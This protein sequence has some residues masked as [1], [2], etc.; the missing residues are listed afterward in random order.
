MQLPSVSPPSLDLVCAGAAATLLLLWFRPLRQRRW[1]LTVLAGAAILGACRASLFTSRTLPHMS[2]EASL[3]QSLPLDRD[4]DYVTSNRCQS[5]HPGEYASWHDTY[6]RTMTQPAN[7]DTVVGDFSGQTID[8]DG[9]SY[10][11]FMRGEEYWARLPDPEEMMEIVMGNKPKDMTKVPL[12]ERQVV[13]TTGSHHYQTYWVTGDE[14]YGRLLQTLPLVYLIGD[15]R[16]IPR[17]QAFMNAP[18][19]PRMITQWNHHCIKCHSTGGNPG[20]DDDV[21]HGRFDTQVA[22][23]G[24]SCEACHG[25]GE[26]HIAANRDPRRRYQQHRA[27]SDD[28]TIV[29]P[30]NL[31]HDRASQICGQCHG[32][33]IH[34]GEA[35]WR[36]AQEGLLYRP[37]DDLHAQRLYIEHPLNAPTKSNWANYRKNREYFRGR[38]WD[39]GTML[40][41][42]REYTAMRA[43]ACF[44][45]GHMSCLSC[46]S[47]HNSHPNDQL[48]A[49][50]NGN[51][52]CVQCHASPEYTVDV[53]AH[54]HHA[55]SSTGSECLNCHMPHIS[56][57]L[58]SAIRS[59]QVQAPNIDSS[60]K[61]GVPNACNLCHL[62]RT[63]EW[64]AEH[65]SNWYGQE[66][67]TPLTQEQTETS[68]ALL[69][70]LKGNAVQR[71]VTAWHVGWEPAREASGAAWLAPHQAQLL[72]DP[73][74]VVRYVAHAALRTLPGMT[75][76][77]YNFLAGETELA[78]SRDT[79]VRLWQQS[80]AD[81]SPDEDDPAR[82]RAKLLDDSGE[83]L[84]GEVARLLSERDNTP[85]NIEE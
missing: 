1:A 52:A 69:W 48:K 77:E 2:S 66:L 46:H 80:M 5:C 63:L 17:E 54:T 4:D 57:A 76:L 75:S 22:E 72:T 59:H 47:M 24:I 64:T 60:V 70:L 29:N 73:Y 27:S 78:Q 67:A 32:S 33:F 68:A 49:D 83:V 25:P 62:D 12:V 51:R 36:Y 74:G 18:G 45:E 21:S 35:G 50:M 16:W 82:Q 61:H 19:R 23:L 81:V 6:H 3:A 53:S 55:P 13:M 39:D 30:A 43:S 42:G 34:R 11:V 71:A 26:A 20:L 14:K 15:Q 85:M 44:Q 40:V 79:A 56:Y 31:S 65:M 38:F 9:L 8:S 7:A 37:G 84:K 58:F 41:A 28:P 10:T